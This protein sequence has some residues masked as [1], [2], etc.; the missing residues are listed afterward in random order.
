MRSTVWQTPVTSEKALPDRLAKIDYEA[1]P[2]PVLTSTVK[3]HFHIR[4]MTQTGFA[5]FCR[6]VA[7]R[8]HSARATHIST[9]PRSRCLPS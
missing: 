4:E 8:I 1:Q 9:V 6:H 2:P 7:R 5:R 3:R